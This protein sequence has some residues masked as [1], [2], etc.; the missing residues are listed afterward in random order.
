VEDPEAEQEVVLVAPALDIIE[1]ERDLD[2]PGLALHGLDQD[3]I[4]VLQRSMG[5]E[6]IQLHQTVLECSD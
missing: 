3:L 4:H 2:L 1:E 6:K 5:I